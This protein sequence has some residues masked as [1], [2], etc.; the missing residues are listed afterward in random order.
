MPFLTIFHSLPYSF[1]RHI[2]F[3][4]IFRSSPYSVPRHILFLVI[5]CR[6]ILS[7]VITIDCYNQTPQCL[8]YMK[9]HFALQEIKRKFDS[10]SLRKFILPVKRN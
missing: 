2:L 10:G 4:A 7:C 3:L 1:P 5:F 8:H 9:W 6:L